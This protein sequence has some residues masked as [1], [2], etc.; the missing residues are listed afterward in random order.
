M[1]L[2]ETPSLSNDEQKWKSNFNGPLFYCHGKIN[3]CGVAISYCGT[4]AFK[5]VNTA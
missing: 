3:S 2:Q 5:V 4:V 1:F